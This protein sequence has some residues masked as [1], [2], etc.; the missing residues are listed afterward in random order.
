MRQVPSLY[1][2]KGRYPYHQTQGIWGQ[3]GC[4]MESCYLF[5]IYNPKLKSLCLVKSSHSEAL[6]L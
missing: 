4:M 2:Q 6:E 1:Q 3:E 5:T